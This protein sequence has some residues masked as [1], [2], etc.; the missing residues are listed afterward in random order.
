MLYQIVRE[1]LGEFVECVSYRFLDLYERPDLMLNPLGDLSHK[2]I[3]K[4]F[5]K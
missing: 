3:L 2:L 5:D 4:L 1:G